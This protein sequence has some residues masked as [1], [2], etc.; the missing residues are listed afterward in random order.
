MRLIIIYIIL[1]LKW[2]VVNKSF[3]LA[4]VTHA[5]WDTWGNRNTV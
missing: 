5:W 4:P 2:L 1:T 3:G